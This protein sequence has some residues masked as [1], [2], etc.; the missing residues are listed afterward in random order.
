MIVVTGASGTT[1]SEVVKLLSAA[2]VPVRAVVRNPQKKLAVAAPGVEPVA[3]DFEQP[4]RLGELLR[5]A[6]RLFLLTRSGP[7]QV[8][9]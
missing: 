5:G 1:G 2:G 6:E 4:H 3:I 9:I 8:D 7:R